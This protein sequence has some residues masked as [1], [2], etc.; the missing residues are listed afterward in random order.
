MRILFRP[1]AR[2]TRAA[3]IIFCIVMALCAMY[4][5]EPTRVTYETYML[6]LFP[7]AQRAFQYGENHFSS[8]KPR[9]YDVR[10]AESFFNR[11]ITLNPDLPLLN[12]ELSRVAFLR[13][14]YNLAIARIN[15]EL[16]DNT[17]PSPTSYYMRG[18]IEGYMG[19][20]DQAVDDYGRFLQTFTNNWAAIND[21]AWVLIKANRYAEAHSALVRGIALFPENA[22]LLNSDATAL[23]EMGST[24]DALIA[25]RGAHAR[26]ENITR[27]QWL[28]AYPGNDPHSADQGIQTLRRSIEANIH[29]IEAA[30]ASSTIQ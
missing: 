3:A 29:M 15:R 12:H 25:A 27:A 21:Y 17:A 16:S 22:W 1:N 26:V 6:R 10:V 13:G 5:W 28:T 20:Y 30:L 24:S 11:A 7:S 2:I 18:L 9:F 19:D 23:F 4:E 14:D 8:K